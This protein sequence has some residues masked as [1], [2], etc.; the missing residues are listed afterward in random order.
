MIACLQLVPGTERYVLH[1]PLTTLG[2]RFVRP[3]LDDDAG[4]P[5]AARFAM[6]T[7]FP[8]ANG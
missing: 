6:E 1:G 4:A 2:D 5:G 3:A 8:G 7:F